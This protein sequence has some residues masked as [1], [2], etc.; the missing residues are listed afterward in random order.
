MQI[1]Q[2]RTST[3]IFV[4][5]NVII[6]KAITGWINNFL[7]KQKQTLYKVVI[8]SGKLCAFKLSD[9]W[10]YTFYPSRCSPSV[11][12]SSFWQMLSA[13][14]CYVQDNFYACRWYIPL[15]G[16]K[17]IETLM[18]WSNYS[19]HFAEGKSKSSRYF[20]W[21]HTFRMEKQEWNLCFLTPSP[22]T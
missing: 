18:T 22:L 16:I 6:W 19:S 7:P 10:E 2:I 8:S 1:F 21:S 9:K 14:K 17:E 15:K 5:E 20:S 4:P 11:L 13:L 3:K 12:F